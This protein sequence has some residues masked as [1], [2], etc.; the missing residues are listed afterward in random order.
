M[1]GK[2]LDSPLRELL[3]MPNPLDFDAAACR[4]G[5]AG[6]LE[7]I[8]G[9]G[10][11]PVVS[12]ERLAG[13]PFAGGWDSKELAERLQAVWPQGS[14]LVV[15]REQRAVIASSY[16]QYV[17]A[18]GACSIERYLEPPE[19]GR[20]RVR[21]FDFGHYAYDR[22][23][24]L[25]HELFAPER[26]HV[27]LYEELE[28]DPAAFAGGIAAFGGR[29]LDAGALDG[30]LGDRANPSPRATEVA[31]RRRLNQLFRQTDLNPAP[32]LPAPALAARAARLAAELDRAVP[33]AAARRLD[34]HLEQAVAVAV[35]DRYRASN[36]A[37]AALIECDLGGFGYQLPSR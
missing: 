14:I 12:L 31:L 13:H 35:G 3:V 19:R 20:E 25:Y 28:R 4:D 33:G 7:R 29:D 10:L 6:E 17:R 24:R 15:I 26:V 8:A 34:Q 9:R 1:L 27:A 21:L 22:L 5:L 16:R 18:G 32:L 2:A 30:R 11:T 36:A 23:I 37:T